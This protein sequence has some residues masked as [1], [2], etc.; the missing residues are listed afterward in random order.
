MKTYIADELSRSEMKQWHTGMVVLLKAGTGRGKSRW[1]MTELYEAAK[2]EGKRILILQNRKMAEDQ[3][4]RD[5]KE[6]NKTDV[7]TIS[8]YQNVEMNK[9]DLSIYDYIICDEAHY[10]ATDC[11]YNPRTD[12]SFKAIMMMIGK[13]QIVFMTATGE[14]IFEMVKQK[15]ETVEYDFRNDY[16][17]I[18]EIIM[19]SNKDYIENKLKTLEQS[20]RKALV[21]LD[22]IEDLVETYALFKHRSMFIC[23]TS[24][25]EYKDLINEELVDKMSATRMMQKQFLFATSALDTGFN[26]EDNTITDVFCSSPDIFKIVQ[27]IG[28]IRIQGNQKI[29]VHIKHVNK[30]QVSGRLANLLEI[31]HQIDTL[32]SSQEDFRK[33]MRK[34]EIDHRYFFLTPETTDVQINEMAEARLH[35]RIAFYNMIV[36]KDNFAKEIED[37]FGLQVRFKNREDENE[38]LYTILCRYENQKLYGKAGSKQF[39]EELG[40]KV[41]YP[42]GSIRPMIKPIEINERIDELGY[43]VVSGKSRN[44]SY[45]MVASK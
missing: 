9:I 22:G 36:A 5:I 12:D 33:L 11:A 17:G 44:G 34:E 18:Q 40:L 21:F 8:K 19:F 26:L 14:G 25:K 7:I 16:S 6:N 15:Y 45:I 1:A 32:K 24:R 20:G 30:Y 38:Q 10:F 37:E 3:F 28:R 4:V 43:Q 31:K 35:R 42:N 41:K 2:Q 29:K 27:W 13:A 39:Y 23:S